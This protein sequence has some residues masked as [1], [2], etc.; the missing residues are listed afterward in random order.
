MSKKKDEEQIVIDNQIDFIYDEINKEYGDGIVTP[1]VDFMRRP[2]QVIPLSPALDVAL[3]GG[4]PEGS[5][6]TLSGPPK[7]GKTTLSIHLC[8]KCQLPENGARDIYYFDIEG[9]LKNMN[10]DVPGLN[11]DK[12]FVVGSQSNKILTAEEYLTIAEK[13]A[14]TKPKSVI[15]L[16]SVS[17]LCTE[18]EGNAGMDEMQRADGPKLL[19]KFCRKMTNIIPVNNLIVVAITH[20]M[21]NPSGYGKA[22]LEKSGFAVRFQVDVKL[23]GKSLE[24]WEV[25]NNPKPVGQIVKWIMET[26]ALGGIPFTEVDS[27]IRYGQGIDELLELIVLGTQL[28]LINKAGA[29]YSCPF[30]S[31]FV[32]DYDEKKFK[33]QGQEKL[34]DFF[35]K[36]PEYSKYLDQAFRKLVN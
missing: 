6:F 22:T 3:N 10:L 5:W 8:K 33:F 31:E 12:F 15:V 28:G 32:T 2:K 36:N 34:Y 9:R 30:L 27:Y 4:I 1:A 25:P 29:W 21:A 24:R 18:T 26:S 35:L 23:V 20:I 17:A 14:R 13:I 11:K 19:A 7:I 16:D